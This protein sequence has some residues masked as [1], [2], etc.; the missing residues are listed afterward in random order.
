MK[1]VKAGHAKPIVCLDAGHYGKYNRSPA[2]PEYYESDMNW[3]LHLLLKVELEKYGIEVR[4]TRADKDTDLGLTARGK[5][6]EGC[7][8][9][10][11]IHSNAAG[12]GVNESVDYPVVYVPLNGSVDVLGRELAE[13]IAN[14]MGTTQKGESKTRKG[15]GD[16][17]YYSVIYGAVSVGT[18]G[19][20]LEHSFHTNTKATKWL[21]VDS[22]LDKLAKAEAE[23]VADWFGVEKPKAQPEPWYRIR[24]SWADAKSQTAAYKSKENAIKACPVGYSVYDWNGKEVYTHT[25]QPEVFT[26]TLPVLRN[27]D[28]GGMV[29]ALQQL[30]M[31]N[32]IDLPRYGADGSFGGETESAVI[33]Y[34]KREE[35]SATG[36]AGAETVGSLLGII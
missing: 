29:M 28:N 23:I 33:E 5:K 15:S 22:N 6:G 36:S 2:V 24:K 31:A 16:W 17:D 18:P 8:L 3:K 35:L 27:G 10:L 12:S 21:M 30:L 7:D 4:T 20:I 34:Q 32:G 9:L 19:L 11:S 14:V 25:L 13:C 1:N 26:I